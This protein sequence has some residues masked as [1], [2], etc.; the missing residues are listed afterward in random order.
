MSYFKKP[1]G[2]ICFHKVISDFG[3]KK[4]PLYIDHSLPFHSITKPLKQSCTVRE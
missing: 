2:F 3:E 4:I 1:L